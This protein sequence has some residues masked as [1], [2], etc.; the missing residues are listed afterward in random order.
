VDGL[1]KGQRADAARWAA[2]AQA[3]I[4]SQ[5]AQEAKGAP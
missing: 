5:K 1:T 4:D 2:Q 3:W